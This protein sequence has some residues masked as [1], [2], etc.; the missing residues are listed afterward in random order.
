[1]NNL[2]P[3]GARKGAQV[4]SSKEDKIVRMKLIEFSNYING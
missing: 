4:I 2:I 3:G 1:M